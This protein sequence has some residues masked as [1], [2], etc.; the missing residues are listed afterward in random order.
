M[1][2]TEVITKNE[3][4]PEKSVRDIDKYLE[5]IDELTRKCDEIDDS[6]YVDENFSSLFK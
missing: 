5:K 6:D 4:N 3:E 1:K 2:C